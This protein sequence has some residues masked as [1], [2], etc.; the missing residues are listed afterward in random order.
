VHLDASSN[1]EL[2]KIRTANQRRTQV[3]IVKNDRIRPFRIEVAPQVLA[4]LRE[5]LENTRFSY[6]TE[7]A[8]WALGT[9][10]VYLWELVRYWHDTYDWRKHET[11]LNR[12]AHFRTEVDDIGLH[13][14]HERGKGPNP[15]PIILTHGYPD[16]FYRFAK[17]ISMLT[18][19]ASFGGRPEDSFDVVVPDLPGYG[20]SDKPSKAGMLFR[21]NDLWA[22]LMKDRLGYERL[23][24]TA[25][26]GA[27]PSQNNSPA[28]TPIPSWQFISPT[29]RSGTFSRS[30]TP[31]PR[32]K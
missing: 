25:E 10:S 15:F 31:P 6:Q 28:V 8:K 32:L 26:T 27:A 12:F 17:I 18:D 1:P 7:G 5:R 13:F 30:P 24:R 2:R 23:G 16:S 19:P 22:R 29:F 3:L 9:D 20:F 4:D 14:I 11:A 21:V